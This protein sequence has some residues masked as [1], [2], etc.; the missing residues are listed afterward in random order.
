MTQA[1]TDKMWFIHYRGFQVWLNESQAEQVR[2][3]MRDGKE[4]VEIDGR[5]IPTRDMA[6]LKGDDN[7]LAEHIK[8][9]DWK[10]EYGHWHEKNQ[11]CGHMLQSKATQQP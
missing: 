10:C 9:G 8:H 2:R 5:M 1:I 3:I 7:T 6:L 4:V 11:G